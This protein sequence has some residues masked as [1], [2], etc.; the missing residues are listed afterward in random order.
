MPAPRR[1]LSVGHSYVVALNRRLA[2][3]MG[4]AGEAVSGRSG[5]RHAVR[6]AATGAAAGRAVGPGPLLGGAVRPGRG[7]DRPVG[8][9]DAG[10]LLHLPEHPEA[11]PA[12]V[13]LGG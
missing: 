6:P 5:P 12:A 10:R 11:L 2:D 7:A 8:R 4:R 1:L 9:A 13:Q 3:E